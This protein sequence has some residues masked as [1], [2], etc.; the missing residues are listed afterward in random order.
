M[1]N[2]IKLANQAEVNL[3]DPTSVAEFYELVY[4]TWQTSPEVTRDELQEPYCNAAGVAYGELLVRTT[5][6][7]W[8][9]AEDSLGREM[10]LHATQNNMLVF[11][12]NAV[13]KRWVLGEDGDFIPLLAG[14]VYKQFG[15]RG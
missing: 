13:E 11:P 9:I 15:G 3:E 10:A 4:S 14:A 8:V 6:L 12:L 7:R 5:P 1:A 2:H